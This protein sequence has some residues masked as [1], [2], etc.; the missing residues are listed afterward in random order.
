MSINDNINNLLDNQFENHDYLPQRLLIEDMDIAA[1]E[2]IKNFNITLF[3]GIDNKTVPLIW[4]SQERW[5]EFKDNWKHAR[6]EGGREVTMPFMTMRRLDV[7]HSESPLNRHTIPLKKA[8]TYLKVPIFEGNQKGYDLWKIPQPP[9]VDITY[10][11]RFLSHY[12]QHVN[13]VYET[14]LAKGFSDGQAYL[15]ING[16]Y[17]YMELSKPNEEN[18]IDDITAD[19]RLQI[20]FPLTLH[21]KIVDTEKFEKKKAI[22]KIQINIKES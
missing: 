10:E 14:M 8:F 9:R 7:M 18:N 20:V 2:Y 17:V 13:T 6:D 12:V 16:H 4:L 5:A 22:T 11:L 19:R 15:F 1:F 21:G 3:D